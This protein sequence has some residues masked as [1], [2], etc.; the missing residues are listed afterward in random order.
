MSRY[1]YGGK[2]LYFSSRTMIHIFSQSRMTESIHHL[3]RYVNSISPA[4][5]TKILPKLN[6]SL[7]RRSDLVDETQILKRKLS[8]LLVNVDG[9][10]CIPKFALP[11]HL[12]QLETYS[13]KYDYSP[14]ANSW[15]RWLM[16]HLV[17]WTGHLLLSSSTSFTAFV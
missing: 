17:K 5:G 10:E 6:R 9:L 15:W 1:R 11:S 2:N 13:N 16:K 7:V 8:N 14:P 4:T 3:V 12:I